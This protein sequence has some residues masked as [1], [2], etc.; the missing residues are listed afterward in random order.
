MFLQKFFCKFAKNHNIMGILFLGENIKKRRKILSIT[1]EHLAELA[2]VSVNTLY[3]IERGEN[4]PSWQTVEKILTVL[5][6]E[7]NIDIKK[8]NN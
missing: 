6:L 8:L 1:Q 3:K 2:D 4:N 7:L 5:G